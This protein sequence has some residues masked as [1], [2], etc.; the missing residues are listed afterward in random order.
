MTTSIVLPVKLSTKYQSIMRIVLHVMMCTNTCIAICKYCVV[1]AKLTVL[2]D[3][4]RTKP[5]YT[6]THIVI[7]QNQ[8][9]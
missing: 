3:Y 5:Q 4:F 8:G 7:I 1:V 9:I 6:P 2:S